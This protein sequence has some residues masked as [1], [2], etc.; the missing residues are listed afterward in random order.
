MISFAEEREALS[1]YASDTASLVAGDTER[2]EQGD[3]TSRLSEEG[4]LLPPSSP[5]G[6]FARLFNRSK[7][8]YE[9]VRDD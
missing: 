4:G 6:W 8:R 3:D 1:E 2:G 5:T 7:H 9:P